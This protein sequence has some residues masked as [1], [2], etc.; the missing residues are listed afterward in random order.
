MLFQ[1][2]DILP[3]TNKIYDKMRPPKQGECNENDFIFSK[4]E[5]ELNKI[6]FIFLAVIF[7]PKL[8]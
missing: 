3:K 6:P 4:F 5:Y 8:W 2:S 7:G 1:L